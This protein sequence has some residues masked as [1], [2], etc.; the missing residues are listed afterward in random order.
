MSVAAGVLIISTS[1]L[2]LACR[3]N[4]GKG[5]PQYLNSQEPIDGVDFTPVFP[6]DHNEK[7]EKDIEKVDFPSF[8]R[9]SST[10]SVLEERVSLRVPE[11]AA[12]HQRA[13]SNSSTL[14]G[15][16]DSITTQSSIGSKKAMRMVIE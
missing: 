10:F 6:D 9:A 13:E 5:L 7:A 16:T 1:G 15:R 14:L 12:H 3:L 11:R 4:F 8:D 2:A